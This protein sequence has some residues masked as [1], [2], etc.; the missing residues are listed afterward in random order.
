M[1]KPTRDSAR[2]VLSIC[3][4]GWLALPAVPQGAP[5]ETGLA[6]WYGYPYHG[7]FAASG[8][9][10]NMEELTAAHPSLPFNTMV[11]VVN[12]INDLSVEVRITDRGPFVEGRI[13]DLSRAAAQRIGLVERGMA[14]VRVE[15]VGNGAPAPDGA[16]A[17]RVPT[18]VRETGT[19][20]LES[21]VETARAASGRAGNTA[22]VVH[23][24]DQESGD[25]RAVRAR[26]AAQLAGLQPG[27]VVRVGDGFAVQSGA[28]RNRDNAERFT[29]LMRAR[30]GSARLLAAEG[31]LGLWRVLSGPETTREGADALCDRIRHDSGENNAFV[32]RLDSSHEPD[33]AGQLPRPRGTVA[34]DSQHP[35]SN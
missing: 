20:S 14:Q 21:G 7:R 17:A 15:V 19:G 13:I 10:F 12:L 5:A 4:A 33:R 34:A 28:F 1:L 32:V 29:I 27:D 2:F 22:I 24:G 25:L 3:L 30:Y 35:S 31:E 11:R 23:G 16:S 6:S 8:E 26:H 18:V 9:L